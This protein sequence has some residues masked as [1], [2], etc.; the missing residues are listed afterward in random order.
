MALAN[1]GW[2]A[3]FAASLALVLIASDRLVLAVEAAGDRYHWP[4]NLVG[5]LAAAGADGPEVSAAI[6]AL[7]AGAHDVSQGVILGSNLFN[8]A[9]LLGLPILLVGWISVQRFGVVV[10]GGAMALITVLAMLLVL[11]AMPAAIVN[12][13]VLFVLVSYAV[14]LGRPHGAMFGDVRGQEGDGEEEERARE[15][16]ADLAQG[17]PSGRRLLVQGLLATAVV[18]AGCN[19]M[20]NATLYLGPRAGI[21]S[22]VIGTFGLAILTSLPNLWVAVT[23]A[24]RHR[25]AVLFS[26]VC[27]SNTI[28]LVFGICIPALVAVHTAAAVV[29]HIDVP[30]L[31]CLTLL[32]VVMV[33]YRHG[34]GR[35]GAAVLVLGYLAFAAVRLAAS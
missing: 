9:A 12:L 34:L 1:A 10:N 16:E 26:A 32:A 15:R 35:M 17:Y 19:I 18:I 20:V 13:L 5:L 7:A 3:A 22:S 33:W 30:A 27:N 6:I 24:R 8:I 28:N 4:P 14:L 11:G 23:L 29:R 2:L 25:G 21:P 31:I